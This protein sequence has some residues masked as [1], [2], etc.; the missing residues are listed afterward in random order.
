MHATFSGMVPLRV[1]MTNEALNWS[2]LFAKNS[3]PFEFNYWN[4]DI[5]PA[6]NVIRFRNLFSYDTPVSLCESVLL[7]T[8]IFC[9]KQ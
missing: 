3:F 5:R 1:L 6:N 4:I 7:N 9:D 2:D 8:K